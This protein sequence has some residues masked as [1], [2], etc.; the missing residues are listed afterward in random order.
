MVVVYSESCVDYGGLSAE[1][2]MR[3][4][5]SAE[6]VLLGWCLGGEDMEARARQVGISGR[7]GD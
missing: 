5:V 4:Y 3:E 6:N 1:E 7:L 2:N